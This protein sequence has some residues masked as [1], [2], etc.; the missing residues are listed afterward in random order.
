VAIYH[1]AWAVVLLPL[2]GI[3]SSFIA[4]TPRRAAQT[5]FASVVLG[6]LLT[7]VVLGAR[8]THPLQP[9][10]ES[11]LTFF[12]MSPPET[13]VF[14]SRFQAQIGIHV[15]SLSAS[16]GFAIAFVVALVQAY[17]LTTL[18][19]DAGYR[20]FFW[21]SSLLAAGTLGLVFSPNLFSTLFA[22]MV[23][24]VAAYLVAAQWWDRGDAAAPARRAYLVL[25]SADLA[26]LL[27]V[28]VV[29]VKFGLYSAQLPAPA[30]QSLV[31]PLGFDQLTRLAQGVLQGAV[32]GAGLRSLA[33]M[34]AILIFAAVVRAAQVPFHVW[35]QETATS[36]VPSV[37]LVMISAGFAG[38][39]LIARV[40][41]LL[42]APVHAIS[43]LA[44]T[45]AVTAVLAA[46]LCLAQR[47]ILRIAIL[48]G[49]AEVGL[50]MAALGTGGYGQGLFVLFTSLL[51]TTLLV[52]TAG[53]LMRV[54]RTRDIHE[55]TGVR[56][57]MRATTFAL[58]VWAAGTAGLS[59]AT[60]YALSSVFENAKP[61]GP[62][63]GGMTRV[64]VAILVV[65]ASALMAAYATRLLAFVLP[66]VPL[67]RRGFQ[68]ERVAE[69]ERTL[70][71][72]TYAGGAAA[73]V[74]VL[75]GLPGIAPVHS[76]RLSI[77]GL[78]FTRFV[79]EYARPTL[80]VDGWALLITLAAGVLGVTLAL[81]AFA[82]ARR[83]ATAAM[84]QPAA[85]VL[86]L[87]ERGF[88]L[89]RYAHRAGVPFMMAAA[90]VRRFDDGITDTLADLA[91]D[92]PARAAALLAGVRRV[93]SSVYLAGGL[94]VA[95]VLAL[96]SVL[97]ATGHFWIH[98]L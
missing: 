90:F 9:P 71:L 56:R 97:A 3:A 30:G 61:S 65:V 93:P 70:R 86:R 62:A 77:P 10:F 4:E 43:A 8:L 54:Y 85:G 42:L 49:I 98:S 73:V 37:A 32:H 88:N 82:P 24:S 46:V 76:G 36:P 58:T 51:F 45:G 33:V 25:Y 1:V 80:P 2:A 55:I 28:A 78:T 18:R 34:A 29:F 75:V 91:G 64:V 92:V 67:R 50:V 72:P 11:L 20:R 83:Q 53:N 35:L 22:W 79:Y 31:D 39:Y 21:T 17:A 81:L 60:Y 84:T 13:T 6:F 94:T 74:S 48:S 40:Y 7:A 38:A 41:P 23:V 5:C 89:E 27:A 57:R 66:G 15:D 96:L 52:L 63:V 19:G 47:D 69:V 12:S 95:F 44:L 16:F 14:A 68:P 59:L 26:L 87:A